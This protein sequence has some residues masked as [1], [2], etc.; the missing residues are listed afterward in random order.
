[1]LTSALAKHDLIKLIAV[2]LNEENENA[3]FFFFIECNIN[4]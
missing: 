2:E 3:Q 4:T 1:M